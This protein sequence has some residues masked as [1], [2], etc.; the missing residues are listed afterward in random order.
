MGSK[1]TSRSRIYAAAPAPDACKGSLILRIAEI[2]ALVMTL[3]MPLKFASMAGAPEM[4]ASYWTDLSAIILTPWPIMVFA[5]LA[6][7]LLG[8]SILAYPSRVKR[9]SPVPA[10]WGALWI[11]LGLVSFI[12]FVNASA[13]IYAYQ[14]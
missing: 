2:F 9:L 1:E 3:L 11:L 6:S 7:L 13:K 10:L 4:P 12:G 14:M 5:L 8:M